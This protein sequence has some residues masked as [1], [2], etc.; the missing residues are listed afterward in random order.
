METTTSQRTSE[1]SAEESRVNET[2]RN[3]YFK[4]KRHT[5]LPSSF[6]SMLV[7]SIEKHMAEYTVEFL[8]NDQRL[9]VM[10][11]PGNYLCPDTRCFARRDLE[12]AMHKTKLSTFFEEGNP[13]HS[14][15]LELLANITRQ[16]VEDHAALEAARREGLRNSKNADQDMRTE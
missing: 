9:H 3:R 15:N 1:L 8:D 10:L 14:M 12:K 11:P 4:R 7:A 6:K 5:P 16:L 2:I 13:L